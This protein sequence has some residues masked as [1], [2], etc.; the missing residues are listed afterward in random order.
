L[1]LENYLEFHC[2]EGASFCA[3]NQPISAEAAE[4]VP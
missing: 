3:A 1:V 4:I 2:G